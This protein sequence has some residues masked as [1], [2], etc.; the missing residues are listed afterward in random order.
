M[1]VPVLEWHEGSHGWWTHDGWPRHQHSLNGALTI[2]PGDTQL[3]FRGGLPFERVAKSMADGPVSTD[4]TGHALAA[5]APL[6]RVEITEPPG[7]SA[8]VQ[9]RPLPADHPLLA[10]PPR[11]LPEDVRQQAEQAIQA[12]SEG[13]GDQHMWNIAVRL[14]KGKITEVLAVITALA[15]V[16]V[17]RSWMVNQRHMSVI[18]DGELAADL[19]KV[20]ENVKMTEQDAV[21]AAVRDWIAAAHLGGPRYWCEQHGWQSNYM[22]CPRRRH[23]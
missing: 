4:D 21:I 10:D 17:Y 2:A 23:R 13:G 1:S 8:I 20:L 9:E 11:P 18:I 3:H 22:P 5:Q 7:G 19:R 6:R 16:E 14:P 15:G 12:A